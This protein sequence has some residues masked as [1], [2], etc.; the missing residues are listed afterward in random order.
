MRDNPP[1][2][3]R[4]DL[5]PELRRFAMETFGPDIAMRI[6]EPDFGLARDARFRRARLLSSGNMLPFSRGRA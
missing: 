5:L 3:W 1:E 2:P 6:R 4:E